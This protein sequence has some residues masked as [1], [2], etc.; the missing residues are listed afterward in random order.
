MLAA[1]DQHE[2][3]E[4]N[5]NETKENHEEKGQPY[6]PG[7]NFSYPSKDSFPQ[8]VFH[9]FENKVY[10]SEVKLQKRGNQ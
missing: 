4:V 2:R 8:G 7:A 10:F 5:G 1:T 6:K 3:G 9:R